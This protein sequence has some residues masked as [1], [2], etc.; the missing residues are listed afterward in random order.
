MKNYFTN[1]LLFVSTTLSEKNNHL[2]DILSLRMGPFRTIA[3]RSVTHFKMDGMIYRLLK[4]LDL[5]LIIRD[6]AGGIGH[7]EVGKI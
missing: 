7:L 2:A 1:N 3:K 4:R 5:H 6:V